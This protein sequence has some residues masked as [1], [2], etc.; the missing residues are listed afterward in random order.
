[1][2]NAQDKGFLQRSLASSERERAH[3]S[4]YELNV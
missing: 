2:V 1:M 3:Y 4:W